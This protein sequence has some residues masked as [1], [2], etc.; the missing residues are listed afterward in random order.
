MVEDGYLISKALNKINIDRSWFY[1]KITPKQ[2]AL[3]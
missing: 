1:K 2:K 3:I